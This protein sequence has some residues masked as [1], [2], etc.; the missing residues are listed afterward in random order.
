MP[1]LISNRLEPEPPEE[2]RFIQ[3]RLN[4]AILLTRM[5]LIR[6]HYESGV[7][8]I[9]GNLS[10]LDMMMTLFHE[11][12]Q[13][14]DEFVL[15]KG[16]AAGALYA[17]LWSVG[18]L[19]EGDL[20]RFHKDG[21]KMSGH[22]APNHLPEIPF[23]TGSLGHGL[24]LACG[25]ALGKRL[26]KQPGRVFCLLSDGEWQEGSNWEALIFLVHHQ[27][28]VTLLI[29]T[30]GLQGFGSTEEIASQQALTEKLKQ[31]GL[32]TVEID[33]HDTASILTEASV[34]EERPKGI[35]GRTIK[36]KGVSFMENRMEWHYLPL[37]EDQYVRAMA[38][39][40]VQEIE[41]GEA[42]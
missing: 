31:F 36:G 37:K 41:F 33:G 24:S 5:R 34:T 21:G 22:P 30:N 32:K 2:R 15:S 29:D 27:L 9:G 6:M 23:A 14:N 19:N 38:E 20:K 25:L 11:T 10:C 4:Q 13:P 12:M 18:K 17:T 8:H 39:L 1:T 26:Q 3:T 16:H 28:P 40:R 42:A 7:G 35:V